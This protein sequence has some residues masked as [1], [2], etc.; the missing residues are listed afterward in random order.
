MLNRLIAGLYLLFIVISSLVLFIGA[1]L[2]WIVTRWF[3]PRLVLLHLYTS[4]WGSLYLW[5]MP[6]WTLVHRGRQHIDWSRTYVV[7][8]NHQSMLDIL[9]AF[10]LFFP[11]KWV[12]KIEIF[13][14]PVIGWN[15]QL[16]RYVKLKRGDKESIKEMM[17]V[18]EQRLLEGSSIYMFPEG[19]RSPSGMIKPFKPGAFLLAKKLELPILPIAIN[20]TKNSLP[21]HS[22]NFHGHQTC[23][24]EVLPAI[25]PDTFAATSV[26]SLTSSVHDLIAS[27]VDEHIN[28]PQSEPSQHSNT[29]S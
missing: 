19:T 21:K 16:N 18:A 3:D 11:F 25:E 26:E 27:K 22:F 20:G 8:S 24:I 14:V 9:L 29:M 2:V 7:V 28:H 23:R 4:F 17:E 12:S 15:M 1:L 13:H 5:L 6:A 10:S